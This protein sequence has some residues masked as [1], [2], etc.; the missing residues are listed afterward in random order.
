MIGCGSIIVYA[1]GFLVKYQLNSVVLFGLYVIANLLIKNEC[2][3]LPNCIK[4]KTN[5][6]KDVFPALESKPN[7]GRVFKT[8]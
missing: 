2:Q 4:Q 3:I 7:K 6:R 5:P 1:C 8:E